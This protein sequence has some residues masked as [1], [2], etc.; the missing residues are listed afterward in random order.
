MNNV[1]IEIQTTLFPNNQTTMVQWK[2]TETGY[3]WKTLKGKSNY[4][5]RFIT[6]F[7]WNMMFQK[8][9]NDLQKIHWSIMFFF[10]LSLS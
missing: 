6:I 3:I 10:W 5:W 2:M 4:Y 7:H 1:S 8:L 9:V